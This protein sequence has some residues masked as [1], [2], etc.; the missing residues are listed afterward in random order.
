M[1]IGE[2]RLQQSHVFNLFHDGCFTSIRRAENNIEF[3]VEVQ[4]LAEMIDPA[5]TYLLGVLRNCQYCVFELWTNDQTHYEDINVINELIA[6]MEI[7]DASHENERISVHCLGDQKSIGG[8]LVFV[9][10]EILLFD[11]G[12]KAIA[13][14]ELQK[15]T[16]RY[17]DR[18]SHKG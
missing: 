5:Y 14:E 15:M 4:Y 13:L 2:S 8:T 1:D 3:Q 6:N 12:G 7:S 11:E 18:F 17:W 16:R 10:D 9:C